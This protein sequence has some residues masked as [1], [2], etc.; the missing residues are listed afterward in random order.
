MA[1]V[2]KGK[3]S[4]GFAREKV[5]TSIRKKELNTMVTGLME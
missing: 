3:F 4:M 2:L 5:F 1:V